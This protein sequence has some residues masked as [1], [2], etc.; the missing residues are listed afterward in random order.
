LGRRRRAAS[1]RAG[2]HETAHSR[3]R[4]RGEI[5]GS[6]QK[7]GEACLDAERTGVLKGAQMKV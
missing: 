4:M 7:H 5:A 6:G 1:G 3:Y 2:L